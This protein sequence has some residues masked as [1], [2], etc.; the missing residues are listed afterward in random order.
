MD[1]DPAPDARTP[2]ARRGARRPAADRHPAD[3]AGARSSRPPA[4]PVVEAPPPVDADDRRRGRLGPGRH[5]D[6]RRLP[7]PGHRHADAVL[8]R[9]PD[10]G[11]R[12]PGVRRRGH[13]L[14]RPRARLLA[15]GRGRDGGPDRLRARPT[16]AQDGPRVPRVVGRPL[17]GRADRA[18][19]L[20]RR[21][22]RAL[23]RRRDA[24]R[25]AGGAGRRRASATRTRPATTTRRPATRRRRPSPSRPRSTTTSTSAT[26]RSASSATSASRPAARRPRTRSRSRSPGAASTPGSRP[27]RPCRCPNRRASTAATASASARPAR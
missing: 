19:R 8:R 22:R 20:D 14:A 16:V 23:R 13:R 10:A 24:L 18:R 7:G 25:P 9:E 12:L 1:R 3:A 5:D 6:P 17:A 15:P 11:Q 26:T 21:L 2:H 27:S 4:A